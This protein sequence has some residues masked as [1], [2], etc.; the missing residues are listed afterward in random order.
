MKNYTVP[1]IAD[2]LKINPETVRRWIQDDKLIGYKSS[3]KTGFLISEQD[4]KDFLKSNPKYAAIAGAGAIAAGG[5]FAPGIAVTAL[6]AKVVIDIM[7]DVVNQNK[8]ISKSY[9]AKHIKKM[10]IKRIKSNEESI[11]RKHN[12]I[13]QLEQEI[14]DLEKNNK[15]LKM[16]IERMTE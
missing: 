1:Q 2:L 7:S 8:T 6:G 12:S 10:L 15:S 14:N 11:K 16:I 3:N 4:L 9:D 13:K 5:L